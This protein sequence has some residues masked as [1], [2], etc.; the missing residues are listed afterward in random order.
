M[1]ALFIKRHRRG[2]VGEIC[3]ELGVST[4]TIRGF[5][6]GVEP[7]TRGKLGALRALLERQPIG[8]RGGEPPSPPLSAPVGADVAPSPRPFGRR[9]RAAPYPRREPEPGPSLLRGKQ[10]KVRALL[11]TCLR[12]GIQMEIAHA[13]RVSTTT[14]SRF[15]RGLHWFTRSKLEE[16]R[17]Y[18]LALPP[19]DR[20]EQDAVRALLAERERMGLHVEIARAFGT[21]AERVN[22]FC[23][24]ELSWPSDTLAALRAYLLKKPRTSDALAYQESVRALLARHY[25]FGLGTLI[26]RELRVSAATILHFRL[27]LSPFP[28]KKLEGLHTLLARLPQAPGPESGLGWS[29]ESVRALLVP[30]YNRVLSHE[31]ADAIDVPH[32]WV[33]R[34]K[35]G[36][37]PLPQDKL[38]LLRAFLGREAPSE[39]AQRRCRE[40]LAACLA[41]KRVRSAELARRFGVSRSVVSRFKDGLLAFP[42]SKLAALEKYLASLRIGCGSTA[43]K[44]EAKAGAGGRRLSVNV[45]ERARGARFPRAS[46]SKRPFRG[47]T[48]SVALR[49]MRIREG[50]HAVSHA[51]KTTTHSDQRSLLGYERSPLQDDPQA[52]GR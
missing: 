7:F 9:R 27:G 6:F 46:R 12:R 31:I 28:A 38:R 25:Y 20:H 3:R 32:A 21:R 5:L 26:T 23:T 37:F 1:R 40:L 13:L 4:K 51:S 41:E 29:Q 22:R 52:G 10:E 16:L 14:V 43:T 11:W 15:K 42:V 39:L 30:R 49:G 48:D 17:K 19:S 44:L 24:G 50:S 8:L 34:F 2:L 47:G 18:L 36:E 35:G 45:E 33:M